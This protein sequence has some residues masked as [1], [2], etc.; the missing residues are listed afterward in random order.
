MPA[1]NACSYA[2]SEGWLI[3][4]DDAL[5]LTTAGL[6]QSE[7]AADQNRPSE[8]RPHPRSDGGSIGLQWSRHGSPDGT[9][10]G[11]SWVTVDRTA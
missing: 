2:V 4:P 11:R 3:V 9:V 10:A 6:G 5:T 8:A 7:P 1:F